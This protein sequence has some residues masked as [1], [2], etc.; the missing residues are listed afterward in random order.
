MGKGMSKGTAEEAGGENKATTALR[1]A[2]K[3]LSVAGDKMSKTIK[4]QALRAEIL[5]KENQIKSLKAELGVQIYDALEKNDTDGYTQI[6]QEQ[7]AKVDAVIAEVDKK[8]NDIEDLERARAEAGE[9]DS[10]KPDVKMVS[11]YGATENAE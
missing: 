1:T 6:F 4:I 8:R 5:L 9:D 2:G 3:R 7:K 10:E 11:N